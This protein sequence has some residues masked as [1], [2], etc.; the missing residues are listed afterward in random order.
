MVKKATKK[1]APKT[2]TFGAAGTGTI[3]EDSGVVSVNL[4]KGEY[5]SFRLEVKGARPVFSYISETK[6]RKAS[7][8][9]GHPMAVYEWTWGRKKNER[10]DGEDEQVTRVSFA[11]AVKYI[12]K[13]D[14]CRSDGTVIQTVKHIEV[15]SQNPRDHHTEFLLVFSK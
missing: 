9:T 8:F 13:I 2:F 1:K 4:N 10:G 5:L 3:F 11:A 7:D 12:L 6:Q 15:K 14:H